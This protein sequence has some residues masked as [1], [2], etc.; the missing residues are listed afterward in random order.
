MRST[1][2]LQTALMILLLAPV[3][4]SVAQLVKVKQTDNSIKSPPAIKN[5]DK[6]SR[7]QPVEYTSPVSYDEIN[8][9]YVDQLPSTTVDYLGVGSGTACQTCSPNQCQCVP[10]CRRLY[11]DPCLYQCQSECCGSLWQELICGISSHLSTCGTAMDCGC[12]AYGGVGHGFGIASPAAGCGCAS[13]VADGGCTDLGGSEYQSC[14]SCA[15]STQQAPAWG[16]PIAIGYASNQMGSKPGSVPFPAVGHAG[17]SSVARTSPGWNRFLTDVFGTPGAQATP[18]RRPTYV[19]ASRPI[20]ANRTSANRTTIARTQT[21]RPAVQTRGTITPAPGQAP[22]IAT[23]QP[24]EPVVAKR[25]AGMEAVTETAMPMEEELSPAEEQTLD[26]L[27]LP[28]IVIP[29]RDA[30]PYGSGVRGAPFDETGTT[31]VS[32]PVPLNIDHTGSTTW[33]RRR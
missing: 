29:Q 13:A 28:P 31:A 25:I 26:E 3:D 24:T 14:E 8:Y 12:G 19:A 11:Q 2:A 10:Y 15:A 4:S 30:T 6:P 1:T 21:P 22:T 23:R 27:P 17:A 18:T 5:V 33:G 16:T 20:P 9:D 7:I 32:V